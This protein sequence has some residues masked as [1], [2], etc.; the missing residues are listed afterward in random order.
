MKK[1]ITIFICFLSL[2]IHFSF[3]PDRS[4]EELIWEEWNKGYPRAV[5]EKKI[6]LVDAY[7]DWCGWCK[8]MDRDTYTNPDII[9]KINKHFVP[10]KF[11]PEVTQTYFVDGNS[12]SNFE[13]LSMLTR[14]QRTGY[15]T[16]FFIITTKR[17]LFVN[18][19]YED[20][21][22]FSATLDRIIAES[23]AQ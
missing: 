5:K 14:N 15:P 7:T 16:T 12:Y 6:V 4:N 20:P 1:I 8:K 2:G 11:N 10:I 17:T 18:P 21:T 13:L 3:A 9:K 19:G 22:K 23:E